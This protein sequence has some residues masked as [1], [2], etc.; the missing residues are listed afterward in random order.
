MQSLVGIEPGLQIALD[1]AGS[2]ILSREDA[3]QIR[4]NDDGHLRRRPPVEFL[5][6]LLDKLHHI[7]RS[8]IRQALA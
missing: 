7:D 2:R 1:G 3:H 4:I 5:S 6:P 8:G